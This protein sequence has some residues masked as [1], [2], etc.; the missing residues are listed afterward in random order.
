MENVNILFIFI[1]VGWPNTKSFLM[2]CSLIFFFLSNNLIF[3][4]LIDFINKFN[5]LYFFQKNSVS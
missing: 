1:E 2:A 5:L 3:F 4:S